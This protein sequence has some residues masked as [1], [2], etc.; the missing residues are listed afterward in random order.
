[1]LRAANM[2]Y[3]ILLFISVFPHVQAFSFLGLGLR[4]HLLSNTDTNFAN[5]Y[6]TPHTNRIN[7][8]NRRA[9]TDEEWD[10]AQSR[11][12][13]LLAAMSAGDETASYWTHAERQD[14]AQSP[15]TSYGELADL[16]GVIE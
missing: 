9:A 7:S 6:R 5:Q 12:C 10:E 16:T 4:S 3:I 2:L 11:G 15:F 14:S 13:N 1:M 8:L